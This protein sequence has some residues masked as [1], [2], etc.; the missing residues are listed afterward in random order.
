VVWIS[1]GE[2]TAS[3]GTLGVK[4]KLLPAYDQYE[5]KA[6]GLSFAVPTGWRLTESAEQIL[7]ERT[8]ERAST[9][10]ESILIKPCIGGD[11]LPVDGT[12]LTE[13][14]RWVAGRWIPY[15]H[16]RRTTQGQT[17]SW[18]ELHLTFP[19]ADLVLAYRPDL[20]FGVKELFEQL[21]ESLRFAGEPEPEEPPTAC[22]ALLAEVTLAVGSDW[23]EAEGGDCFRRWFQPATRAE[24]AVSALPLHPRPLLQTTH[25]TLQGDTA[26]YQ[27]VMGQLP[28]K[29]GVEPNWG[30]Q[31]WALRVVGARGGVQISCGLPMGKDQAEGEALQAQAA[32]LCPPLLTG[33]ALKNLGKPLD[34]EL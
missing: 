8:G 23:Q 33:V 5:S 9:P 7:L 4:V 13:S 19:K 12:L 1:T 29:T 32:K 27:A 34:P 22:E 16:L 2:T 15:R 6:M 31:T 17:R 20:Q 3:A 24:L 26:A 11:C 28:R 25:V 10:V 14:E 18:E 30:L 21:A